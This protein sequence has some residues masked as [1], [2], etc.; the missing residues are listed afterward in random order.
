MDLKIINQIQKK[1]D[2]LTPTIINNF[3]I[4]KTVKELKLE[5]YDK[6][7]LK[8]KIS[9]NRIGLFYSSNKD[10][11]KKKKMHYQKILNN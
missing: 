11:R 7:N 2:L 10:D 5:I 4:N 6:L 1:D 8:G 3:D 9:L